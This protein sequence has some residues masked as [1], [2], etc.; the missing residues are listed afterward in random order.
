MVPLAEEAL[1]GLQERAERWRVLSGQDYLASSARD[2]NHIPFGVLNDN[3]SVNLFRNKLSTSHDIIDPAQFMDFMDSRSA[4]A[5]ALSEDLQG[6][7]EIAE[8]YP[9][10]DK[11]IEGADLLKNYGDRAVMALYG[12]DAHRNIALFWQHAFETGEMPYDTTAKGFMN[13]I[14]GETAS[15]F[16]DFAGL[17]R[18]VSRLEGFSDEWDRIASNERA[19]CNAKPAVKVRIR[20]REY[21]IQEPDT[22]YR[23][24]A[25]VLGKGRYFGY[26]GMRVADRMRFSS[27]DPY[28][29]QF[30]GNIS[31]L[32]KTKMGRRGLSDESFAMDSA[33]ICQVSKKL[34]RGIV[35]DLDGAEREAM[36]NSPY[37]DIV[38][39]KPDQKS[40][41]DMSDL[42]AT[43]DN[44]VGGS[45]FDESLGL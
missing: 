17:E 13:Q 25:E 34:M 3:M 40:A 6:W 15:G 33:S 42:N 5:R 1:A 7:R 21:D 28:V 44:L 4:Q 18:L 36:L 32:S 37:C 41:R 22:A 2:L 45:D 20:T 14:A 27:D 11:T 43:Y 31:Y 26:E 9:S 35:L 24:A 29:S 39:S 12:V 30:I 38:V 8:Q 16:D 10:F 23:Y 19:S